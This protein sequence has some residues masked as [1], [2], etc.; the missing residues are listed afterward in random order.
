MNMNLEF[1]WVKI[2]NEKGCFYSP[3]PFH[4][5]TC[6]S[7][8]SESLIYIIILGDGTP[9]FSIFSSIACT[10]VVALIIVSEWKDTF[11]S[12]AWPCIEEKKGGGKKKKKKGEKAK[13]K[14][15][16]KCGN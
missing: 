5:L 9:E 6:D 10:A 13:F 2:N 1:S 8:K 16:A 3:F 15:C 14:R 4:S 12:C 7:T 11:V